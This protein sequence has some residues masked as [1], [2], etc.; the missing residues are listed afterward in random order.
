M[1]YRPEKDAVSFEFKGTTVTGYI[2]SSTDIEPH[3]HW[4][5]LKDVNLINEY[6]DSIAFKEKDGELK[7]VHV[8]INHLDF[9]AAVKD[10]VRK[11]IELNN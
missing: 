11:H 2:I 10:C 7:S 4:F 3:Y 1:M 9:I 5:L 8:M 6:G